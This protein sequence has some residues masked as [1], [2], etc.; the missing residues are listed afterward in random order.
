MAELL[1]PAYVHW[2]DEATWE[3]I[4]AAA[5]SIVVI[6]PMN[7]PDPSQTEHYARILKLLAEANVRTRVLGYVWCD[8]F[9][10]RGRAIRA[11]ASAYSATL[12]ID[13]IFW[14]GI[15]TTDD[16]TTRRRL[17]ALHDAT[18]FS[19]Y[20]CGAPMAMRWEAMLPG[21]VFVTFEG[22]ADDYDPDHVVVGG[23]ACHLVH[24]AAADWVV[25]VAPDLGYRCVTTGKL[26][27][28]WCVF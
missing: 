8:Y 28:P 16:R 24:S 27:N 26:P 7:G 1:V 3:R 6:N 2:S 20:N 4:V 13:G 22:A 21:A 9:G 18:A 23:G 17:R 5:P 14:D 25:P 15:P 11:D 19:V 12:P 10:R